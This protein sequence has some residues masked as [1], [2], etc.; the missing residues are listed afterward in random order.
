MSF[1]APTSSL[2]RDAIES[3]QTV[4]PNPDPDV[5]GTP[6]VDAGRRDS[7]AETRITVM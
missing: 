5:G 7:D 2:D 1:Y 6:N 4:C 3:H